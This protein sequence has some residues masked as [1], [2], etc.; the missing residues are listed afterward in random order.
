[1]R[2]RDIS[3]ISIW[4]MHYASGRVLAP[5]IVSMFDRHLVVHMFASTQDGQL[6]VVLLG[7]RASDDSP[8]A[9]TQAVLTDVDA[10]AE[11]AWE[12]LKAGDAC[13]GEERQTGGEDPGESGAEHVSSLDPSALRAGLIPEVVPSS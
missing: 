12:A 13:A 1:M 8:R 10:N 7:R 2:L 5:L 9:C 3:P 6:S 11:A 4:Y